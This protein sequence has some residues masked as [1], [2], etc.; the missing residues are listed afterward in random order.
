MAVYS[1]N[2][3]SENEN[4]FG[5]GKYNVGIKDDDFECLYSIFISS[6]RVQ[7]VY[8]RRFQKY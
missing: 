6:L 4:W 7:L 1:Q 3:V 5:G 8:N 2:A